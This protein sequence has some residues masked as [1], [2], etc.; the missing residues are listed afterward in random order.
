MRKDSCSLVALS[1]NIQE[2]VHPIIWSLSGL[3]FDCHTVMPV[4]KPIGRVICYSRY[5][6]NI[7]S[8]SSILPKTNHRT[9]LRN[10]GSKHISTYSFF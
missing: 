3:P 9:N 8:S 10:C 6:L 4:P 1:L 5:C 7:N 2:K